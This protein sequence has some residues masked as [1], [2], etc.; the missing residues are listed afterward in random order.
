MAGTE[1]VKLF[2]S[3]KLRTFIEAPATAT[4][5]ASTR[6]FLSNKLRTFIEATRRMTA[7]AAMMDI[8]EQ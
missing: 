4:S 1:Y 6:K 3:N 2:L 7:P 8:P 5:C